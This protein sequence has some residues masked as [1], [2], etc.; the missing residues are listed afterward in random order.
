M[1]GSTPRPHFTDEN[2]DALWGKD[3]AL[4]LQLS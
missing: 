4:G 1:G 3:A 2:V